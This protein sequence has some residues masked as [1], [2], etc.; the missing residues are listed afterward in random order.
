LK[1]SGL[2]GAVAALWLLFGGPAWAGGASDALGLQTLLNQFC[3]SLPVQLQGP[4]PQYPTYNQS[5]SPPKAFSPGTPIAVELA[6]V[7]NT[8]PDVAR[9]TDG[10]CQPGGLVT[11]CPQIGINGINGPV[12]MSS[13][14]SDDEDGGLPAS[15]TAL[16]FLNPLAFV[17]APNTAVPLTP[18]QNSDPAANSFVYAAALQDKNGQP[19]TLDV[20]YNYISAS[21]PW[22]PVKVAL[23]FPLAVLVN[24]AAAETSIVAKLTATCN[25]FGFCS[26][27]KVTANL[28]GTAKTSFS[29]ADLGLSFSYSVAASPNSSSANPIAELRVPLL[30]STQ[31]D[32]LYFLDAGLPGCP[33]GSN[34]SSGYCNAFSATTPPNGFAPK[35]LTNTVVGMAPSAAPQCTGDPPAPGTP[36]QP[37]APC[38]MTLPSNPPQP[39]SPTF[40]FCASF[41]NNLA[42]AFYLA[43]GTDG[44]TLYSSPVAPLPTGVPY[45]ACPS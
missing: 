25:G 39:L 16:S 10:D 18:T 44:T 11:Y 34:L 24:G 43:V 1:T 22:A 12:P 37:G 15:P 21:S 28:P 41:S 3:G 13:R 2:P 40:G 31:T 5:T 9:I 20:F 30:L 7:Q 27:V 32:P 36:G 45:P 6:A 42:A 8:S 4:C 23:S 17:S 33:N 38:P 29:P 14:H 26:N 35:F 19:K